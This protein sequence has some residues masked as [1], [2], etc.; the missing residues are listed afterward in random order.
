[1]Y[2]ENAKEVN[3]IHVMLYP[4]WPLRNWASACRSIPGIRNRSDPSIRNSPKVKRNKVFK[5]VYHNKAVG[6]HKSE[7]PEQIAHPF[8]VCITVFPCGVRSQ[9]VWLVSRPDYMLSLF[10]FVVVVVPLA[11]LA[12]VT[13]F[14][15][16]LSVHSILQQS[17]RAARI[18]GRFLLPLFGIKVE[19]K[20]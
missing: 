6:T 17:K 7:D 12:S 20:G 16:C 19:V 4:F 10:R 1:M 15:V 18:Y 8:T 13:A 5:S 11:I 14:V 2:S 9:S 3:R